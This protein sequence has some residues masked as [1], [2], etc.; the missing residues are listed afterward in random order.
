MNDF[1]E[2]ADRIVAEHKAQY[3]GIYYAFGGSSGGGT[4]TSNSVTQPWS[5][6]E[7]YLSSQYAAA[8]NL[9]NNPSDYPQLYPG[10]DTGSQVAQLNPTETNAI[11]QA[12][13][14]SNG[15]SAI[16]SA[17]TSLTNYNNGN[18]LSAQNPYFANMAQTALAQIQPQIEGGFNAGN[19]LNN[20]AA[21][22]ATAQGDANAVGNLAYQNYNQQSQNQLTAAQDSATND[23]AQQQ[24]NVNA[25][26]AG[27]A[28]QNTS[29]NTISSQVQGYNYNQ[30]LPYQ[31]LQQY[32]NL[33]A[34]NP[35][36]STTSTQPYY[37]NN[38]QNYVGDA[39]SAA[40]IAAMFM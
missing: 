6:Q 1:L 29:Q 40:S 3:K 5:G 28:A 22:F 39:L 18:M 34:G 24:A 27:Q 9:Y 35:G 30:T 37:N 4:T 17:N 33:I 19:D 38:T 31:M 32:A 23:I 11:T 25:L 12:G 8:Q 2:K 13:N 7:P 15:T 36:S 26:T 10:T 14:L 21:A 16:N 20:P